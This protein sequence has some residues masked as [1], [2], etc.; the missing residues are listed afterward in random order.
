MHYLVLLD[1]QENKNRIRAE[2]KFPLILIHTPFGLDFFDKV[3][4]T[5]AARIYAKF[6]IYL[7]PIITALAISLIAMSLIATFSNAA[8]RAGA[9]NLGPQSNLLIPGLNPYLPWTYG[10]IALVVTIIIHEAG[11]G[12]VARVYNVKVDSTGLLLIL[13]FP[14]GAFVNISQEELSRTPLKQKSAIL[15]AGPLNNMVIAIVSLIALY[16]IASNLTPISTHNIPQYGVVVIG[17]GDHSLAGSIGLSKGAIVETVAGQKVHNTDD[18]L[19]TLKSNLGN[20]IRIMWQDGSGHQ[21]TRSVTLPQSVQANQGVLGVSITNG[22]PDPVQVLNKY[23]DAFTFRS[24][25]IFLLF[26]PTIVQEVVPYSDLMA[27]KYHSSILG[28]AFPAVANMIFW[29]MFFNFNVG[30]FNALPIGPLDGGQFYNSLIERK[31][32]SKTKK[33]KNASLVV[34]LVMTA[35]VIMSV[36]VPWLIR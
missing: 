21:I 5:K 10:W 18:L 11:H 26:P 4:T 24:N 16:F 17:V 1:Q 13:G 31:V 22:V 8:A 14:I 34:T 23:K 2:V 35:V 19:K 20:T 30:I 25:P 12:I 29:L 6:N 9:R 28:P 32:N 33:L 27:P 15:T 3:A 7:M 36:F